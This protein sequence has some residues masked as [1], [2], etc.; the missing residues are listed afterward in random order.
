MSSPFE[1]DPSAAFRQALISTPVRAVEFVRYIPGASRP[2]LLRCENGAYYVVKSIATV[3]HARAL[4]NEMFAARLA[5]LLALPI[6][7]PATVEVPLALMDE[8]RGPLASAGSK[9]LEFGSAYPHPP[10]QMLVVDFLPDRLLRR[11]M[12]ATSAFPGA[13][14]FDIW[15]CNRGRREA[16][17]TRPAWK[18]GAAY[19]VWLID[20]EGCFNAGNWNS[21][22]IPT[23]SIYP[24]R[25]VYETVRG[26]ESIEP[27]L[28]RLENITDREIEDCARSVPEEWCGENRRDILRLAEQLFE[29]RRR[30]RRAVAD[31]MARNFRIFRIA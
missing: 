29:R 14:V 9:F 23:P 21:L 24:H 6:C 28:S 22:E 11:V 30:I 20:H 17:F 3:P 26:I 12:N 15:T 16:I 5:L 27:T 18:D 13:L 2:R 19:S 1:V 25:L 4:A 7:T 31:V 10:D 8:V